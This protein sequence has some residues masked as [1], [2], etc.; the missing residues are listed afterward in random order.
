MNHPAHPHLGDLPDEELAPMLRTG[1]AGAAMAELYARHNTAVLAYA[2][3]CCRDTHTAED[4]TAEAFTRTMEAVRAGRG[5]TGPWRPYLLT[6]VRRTAIDWTATARRTDLTDDVT[7]LAGEAAHADDG[8]EHALRKE[9][10]DLVVR[11]FR[12]LPGRWQTVLWHTV[13]EK[14]GAEDIGR[15]L[16]LSP[17]GVWSLAE[18]A[19]EGLREAYLG[20]H[21]HEP[22]A[23][24][25]CSHYR[26]QLATVVRRGRRRTRPLE[27]HLSR[28]SRCRTAFTDLTHLNS[29]LHSLLPAAVLV[30]G[31]AQY[32]SRFGTTAAGNAAAAAAADTAALAPATAA[33][34]ATAAGT[35]A[36]AGKTIGTTLALAVLAG[37]GTYALLPTQPEQGEAKP[38]TGGPTASPPPARSTATAAP[39]ASRAP[40]GPASPSPSAPGTPEADPTNPGLVVQEAP[41]EDSGTPPAGR[42]R[43]RIDSTGQCMEIPGTN[44]APGTQPREAACNG[45]GSQNWDVV[46]L[47]PGR[48]VSVRNAGTGMCLTHTGTTTD[49]A[50]VRQNPCDAAD[51]LQ[52]WT[53][54]KHKDGR[55]GIFTK[56][57][58][59]L[60]LKQ[61]APAARGET[62]D[63]LIATTRHY[64]ASPSL[65]Y[66]TDW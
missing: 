4:L 38:P 7:R 46:S 29:R 45:T 10:D 43:L 33:H 37:I 30:W 60:G 12:A 31:V 55:A 64:Y 18:R 32:L 56:D 26:G 21:V 9:E 14:E 1:T 3:T 51:P 50:P 24:P 54:N 57:N 23:S 34:S 47:G 63:T 42:T 35:T 6:V 59:Y 13:V 62:H 22:D 17:S 28:C 53:M 19:R 61:W 5:P 36:A 58:M 39:I 65:H 52:T 2:R 41:V 27:T 11:S 44:P 15:I 40:T 25:E 20:A 8:Q 66:R 16:G 48:Q 49:G